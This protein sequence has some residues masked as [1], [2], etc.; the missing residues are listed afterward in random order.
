MF[1]IRQKGGKMTKEEKEPLTVNVYLRPS[2][3]LTPSEESEEIYRQMMAEKIMKDSRKWIDFWR[4]KRA[5][6]DMIKQKLT[7]K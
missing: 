7:K 5:I 3:K 2:K 4:E 1:N 6:Q